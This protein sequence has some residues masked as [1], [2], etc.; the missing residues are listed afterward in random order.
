MTC[1][2]WR[3]C[4]ILLL[5]LATTF[6]LTAGC[7]WQHV[8]SYPRQNTAKIAPHCDLRLPCRKDLLPAVTQWSTPSAA[9]ASGAAASAAAAAAAA[10]DRPKH[11][12][13]QLLL[14]R[15]HGARRCH[16]SLL[17]PDQVRHWQPSS[18]WH[19]AGASDALI[20]HPFVVLSS[21]GMSFCTRTANIR[22]VHFI[23]H[24]ALTCLP[25][26]CLLGPGLEQLQ[27]PATVCASQTCGWCCRMGPG[28]VAEHQRRRYDG[29]SGQHS[30]VHSRAVNG[31]VCAT[32]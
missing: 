19:A 5:G 7:R 17:I 12:L 6:C 8:L 2:C 27:C 28:G 11:A 20:Q 32:A 10:G 25:L 16:P 1:C 3:I 15:Q 14:L 30:A 22:M 23:A 18:L 29:Q 21:P 31:R 24:T 13:Q 4:A 26:C 9:A